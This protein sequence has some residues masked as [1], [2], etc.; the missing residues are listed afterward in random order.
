MST[1][2]VKGLRT[3]W[4]RESGSCLC[5]SGSLDGFSPAPSLAQESEGS[6]RFD[7]GVEKAGVV[8]VQSH[9]TGC[10]RL[11]RPRSAF[12]MLAGHW[13]ERDSGE[14]DGFARR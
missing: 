12:H 1:H 4:E 13:I 8:G 6:Q 14:G 7:G 3:E 11:P 5:S 9:G 10:R 2:L